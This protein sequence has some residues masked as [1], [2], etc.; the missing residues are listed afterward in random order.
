[1]ELRLPVGSFR[2]AA[3]LLALMGASPLGAS[4]THDPGTTA[5]AS[6]I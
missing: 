6:Q 4:V 1:V 3:F 2:G 5:P